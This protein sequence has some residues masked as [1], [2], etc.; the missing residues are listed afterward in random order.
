[1]A[2]KIYVGRARYVDTKY[3]EICKIWLFPEGIEAINANVDSNGSI[4]LNMSEMRYPD[5]A[6]FTHVL[7]VDDWKPGQSSTRR[8]GPQRRDDGDSRRYAG[9][10]TGRP[11]NRGYSRRDDGG[12]GAY[13]NGEH[14]YGPED[15]DPP[16]GPTAETVSPEP[17]PEKEIER[18]GEAPAEDYSD[19][20]DEIPF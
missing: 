3:G 19:I 2:E 7:V 20:D 10:D 12:F 8:H 6:G 11:E 5:G 16:G 9:R 1:M 13:G 17:F 14:R 4:N 15:R 18:G